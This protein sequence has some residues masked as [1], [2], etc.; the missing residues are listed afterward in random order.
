MHN[1]L[2]ALSA[3]VAGAVTL[4]V[5]HQSLRRVQRHPARLDILGMRAVRRGMRGVGL[6]PPRGVALERTAL[7]GDLV[8]N[9]LYYSAVGWSCCGQRRGDMRSSVARGAA[10]GL[11]A[12][13]GA[14]VLP[15]WLG[16]GRQ[17][18][19]SAVQTPVM[20]VLLYTAGGVAA[21]VK[22]AKLTQWFGDS[23][24]VGAARSH[25]ESQTRRLKSPR[26][27]EG[28][29]EV[30]EQTIDSLLDIL[31]CPVTR[32]PLRREGDELVAT[33]PVGRGRRYPIRDGIPVLLAE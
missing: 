28:S 21:G 29:R 15:P 18:N 6:R 9:T 2:R 10:L 5:L 16:L 30:P 17:P 13:V 33:Q 19:R 31:V 24:H 32:S 7:V 12:G 11:V 14:V 20:K 4:T 22:Y 8:S 3:G 23:E 27:G 26:P 1:A 25:G